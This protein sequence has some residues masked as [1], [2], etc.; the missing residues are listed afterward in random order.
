MNLQD[1]G[2]GSILDLQACAMQLPAVRDK[3]YSV[4]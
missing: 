1:T 4:L 3:G 2:A